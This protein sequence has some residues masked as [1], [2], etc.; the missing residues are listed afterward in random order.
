MASSQKRERLGL[1]GRGYPYYCP[2]M[3]EVVDL[4]GTSGL[5]EL[6]ERTRTAAAGRPSGDWVIGRGWEY[7]YPAMERNF[8]FMVRELTAIRPHTRAS[9]V[10]EG[11]SFTVTGGACGLPATLLYGVDDLGTNST[12][13]VDYPDFGREVSGRVS[14]GKAERGILVCTSGIGMSITAN[15]VCGI[16]AALCH[17]ELT[18]QMSRKHNDA[19]VLCIPADWL[20]E[21]RQLPRQ[22]RTR[23]V[24]LCTNWLWG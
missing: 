10:L 1:Y 19:N 8:M 24:S 15:K 14:S 20:G 5:D 9:N 7:D 4:R 16:R 23:P 22:K 17:D 21:D 3:L 11:G 2:D 18:A 13:S 6:I 12:D